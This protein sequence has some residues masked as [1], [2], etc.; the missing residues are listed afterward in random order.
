MNSKY[1]LKDVLLFMVNEVRHGNIL[2]IAGT[3]AA[4]FY[5]G[6]PLYER[7]LDTSFY[8]ENSHQVNTEIGA[9]MTEMW[10]EINKI[11]SNQNKVYLERTPGVV[12]ST[13]F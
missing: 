13:D 9:N 11:K 4:Y 7:F 8:T 12:G 2:V 10:E 1:T 5:I 3:I 6:L